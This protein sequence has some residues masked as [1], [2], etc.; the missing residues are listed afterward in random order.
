MTYGDRTYAI[1]MQEERSTNYTTGKL[2]KYYIILDGDFTKLGGRINIK[3]NKKIKLLSV[4]LD[5][6]QQ[7][8]KFHSVALD[9]R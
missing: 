3:S 8:E 1:C 9:I 7:S 4:L 2:K 6:H 5:L